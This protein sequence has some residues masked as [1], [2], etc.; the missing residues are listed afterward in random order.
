MVSVSHSKYQNY[1]R[2][3]L[4]NTAKPIILSLS[5]E[6]SNICLFTQPFLSNLLIVSA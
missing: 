1:K 2:K 4:E 5:K 3:E 6:A